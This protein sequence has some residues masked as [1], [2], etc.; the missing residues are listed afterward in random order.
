MARSR[1]KKLADQVNFSDYH[2]AYAWFAR[3]KREVCAALAAR[4]GLRMLPHID[5][6]HDV[7]DFPSRLA[8]PVFR[9]CLVAWV[10]AQ[11]PSEHDRLRSAAGAAAN[12]A[13]PIRAVIGFARSG[14]GYFAAAPPPPTPHTATLQLPVP[15][16]AQRAPPLG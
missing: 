5:D 12:R 8:L 6:A 13:T 10:V 1:R 9:A 7:E 4:A 14:Q 15:P 2:Q 16:P 11:Y 3:Q